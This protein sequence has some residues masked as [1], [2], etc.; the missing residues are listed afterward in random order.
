MDRYGRNKD[1]WDNAHM[2]PS[3]FISSRKAYYRND[4][5]SSSTQQS[6]QSNTTLP[7][8]NSSPSL[9]QQSLLVANDSKPGRT[10]KQFLYDIRTYITM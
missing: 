9:H 3:V 5:H 2:S 7:T 1:Y 6:L 10:R 4:N 8:T